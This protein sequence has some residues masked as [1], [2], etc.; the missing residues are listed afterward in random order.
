MVSERSKA[1]LT[2]MGKGRPRGAKN[3]ITRELRE[4]MRRVL[5]NPD[6]LNA[7]EARIQAGKATELERFFWAHL[8]GTPE[9]TVNLNARGE[10]VGHVVILPAKDALPGEAPRALATGESDA[11]DDDA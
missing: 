11:E 2:N 10:P 3:R 1:N 7:L 5:T 8:A 6:Y 4:F 9:K